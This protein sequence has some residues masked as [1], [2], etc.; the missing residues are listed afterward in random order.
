MIRLRKGLTKEQVMELSYKICGRVIDSEEYKKAEKI[1]VYN[2]VNGEVSLKKLIETAKK[3]GKI[4]AYPLCRKNRKMDALVPKS[5]DAFVSGAFGIM[6]PDERRSVIIEPEEID[7][8]ICPLTAF[9]ESGRRLGMGGGYYDR[10]LPKCKNAYI[11]AAA[12]EFQ[13]IAEVPADEFDF[14]MHTVF[15]EKNIYNWQCGKIRN[16]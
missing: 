2:A 16:N 9:D 15:T 14:W 3:E 10:Y 13:K 5:A 6:E 1:L 7:L 4:I 11:A 12:Y 8:V